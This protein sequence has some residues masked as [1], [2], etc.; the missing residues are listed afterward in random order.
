MELCLGWAGLALAGEPYFE[1]KK[2]LFLY[3]EPGKDL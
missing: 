2:D 1:K 3:L